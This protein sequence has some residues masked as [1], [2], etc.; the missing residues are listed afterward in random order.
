MAVEKWAIDSGHSGI[1]LSVR[2][3][4]IARVCGQ[5][6]RWSGSVQAEDG[7]LCRAAID[8]VIDADSIDTGHARR[9]LHLRSADL[10][11]VASHPQITFKSREVKKVDDELMHV[12]G[13]LTIRGETRE[14]VLEVEYAG[15]TEDAWGNVRRGFAAKTSIDRKD[16]GLEWSQLLEA[17]GLM[18]GD[19]V[20]IEI[21]VEAIKQVTSQAA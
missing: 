4:V 15:Q 19:H 7:D 10:L 8:V 5:F 13:D 1:H 14:V 17:G 6:L 12:A 3:M 16:F 21:E 18:V 2:C 11:D 9:D 20:D